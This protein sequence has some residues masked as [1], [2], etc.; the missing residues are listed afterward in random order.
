MMVRRYIYRV[1]YKKALE[2]VQIKAGPYFKRLELMETIDQ[3]VK[4][5]SDLPLQ[6]KQIEYKSTGAVYQGQVRGGFREGKGSMMWADGAK[7]DGEWSFGFAQGQGTF[8]HSDGDEYNG[9]WR[10]NKCNG[11]GTYTTKRGA[12][13]EGEWINDIQCG[14]GVEIW[15]EGGKYDGTY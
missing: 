14:K 7:Y 10:N 15:P 1:R 6:Y 13:Y 8:T 11:F 9:E 4:Y 2:Q 5:D 12:R 3:N